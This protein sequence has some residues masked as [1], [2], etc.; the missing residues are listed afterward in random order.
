MVR[1][2]FVTSI[3]LMVLGLA[4]V[5][6]SLRMPDYADVGAEPWSAPG[7]VPGQLGAALVL[8]AAILCLRSLAARRAAGPAPE[9]EPVERGC[10]R[11]A[12]AA[13]LCLVYAAGL[14]GRVPFWL[15]TFLF[16]FAF[17]AVFEFGAPGSRWR[18][19]VGALAV[20]GLTAAVVPWIFQGVFLVRLP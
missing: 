20:A 8:L 5:V 4:T 1:A 3:V 11:V 16:V 18:R 2:D 9:A 19:A 6:A 7:T 13:G 15:A 14:V 17:V 10:G 12:A